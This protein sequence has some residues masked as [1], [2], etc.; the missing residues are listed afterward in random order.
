MSDVS[1]QKIR[2]GVAALGRSGWNIHCA[3]FAKLT[4]QYQVV[5]VTDPDA[6]RAQEAVEKFGC[7]AHPSFDALIADPQVDLVVV[8]TPNRLHATHSIQALEAGKHVV[9]EKPFGTTAE[10]ADLLVAAGQRSGKVLA[11]FQNLRYAPNFLKV[12]EVIDSGVLGRIVHVRIMANGFGRRWDWQ[13]L[14]EFGGGVLNNTGP[15]FLDHLLQLIGPGEPEIFCHMDRA[16]ASG[17]AED[18]VKLLLRIEGAP[19][20][21]LEISRACAYPQDTWLIQGASGTLRG[22][23]SELHW[24][25]VDFS[26]MPPRP[27]DRTPTA[28]RSYN[29]EKLEFIEDSWKLTEDDP[30][31]DTHRSFYRDLYQTLTA[32]A[33]LVVTPESVQRQLHVIEACQA[34]VFA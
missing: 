26:T 4:D 10:E 29:S 6:A 27:V 15:H 31:A 23:T 13:C 5:A 28:G 11:P 34:P 21:E 1:A 24:K 9:C 20:G 25:Y 7:T 12:R 33:P 2:V 18:Y 19:L 14:R 30:N 32:G 8:A 22:S 17:D 3:A 16:L